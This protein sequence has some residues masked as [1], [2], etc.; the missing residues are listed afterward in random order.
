MDGPANPDPTTYSTRGYG[1]FGAFFTSE[2]TP[3]K[4][5]KVSYRLVIRDITGAPTTQPAKTD[6]EAEYQNFVKPL[7][8]ELAK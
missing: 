8:V 6:V 3:Q 4:P 2:V 7:K 5:L 1:R